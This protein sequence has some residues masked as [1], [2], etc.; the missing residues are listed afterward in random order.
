MNISTQKLH[1]FSPVL[2]GDKPVVILPLPD[3]EEIMEDLEMYASRSFS[4]KIEQSRK[5]TKLYSLE[6]VKTK[7]N[8]E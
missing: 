4:E 3:F 2:L 1:N 5:N 6:E 7:L 8:I